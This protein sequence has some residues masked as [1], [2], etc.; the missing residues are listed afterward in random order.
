MR[1]FPLFAA[2]KH[3]QV[4]QILSPTKQKNDQ[5]SGKVVAE[6]FTPRTVAAARAHISLRKYVYEFAFER[7]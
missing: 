4:L 1:L 7:M 5:V 3:Q 2:C 6:V